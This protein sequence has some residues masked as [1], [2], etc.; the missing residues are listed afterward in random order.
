[1]V[2]SRLLLV[3]DEQDWLESYSVLLLQM[4]CVVD[5]A[6]SESE[7]RVK[8]KQ[9]KPN[10][11]LLNA[12]LNGH[13]TGDAAFLQCTKAV[14][15]AAENGVSTILYSGQDSHEPELLRKLGEFRE[16]FPDTVVKFLLRRDILTV[17][18]LSEALRG[19]GLGLPHSPAPVVTRKG[20]PARDRLKIFQVAAAAIRV[21]SELATENT[22]V[23]D[24]LVECASAVREE[25]Y[26]L[27]EESSDDNLRVR[28]GYFSISPTAHMEDFTRAIARTKIDCDQLSA[29]V[30]RFLLTLQMEHASFISDIVRSDHIEY[31]DAID[32]AF[33]VGIKD[34]PP[35][36]SRQELAHRI[37]DRANKSEKTRNDV[38]VFILRKN[39]IAL[40]DL[41]YKGS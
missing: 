8:L 41:G 29:L 33:R 26:R 6:S 31:N 10:L 5:R 40:F 18:A 9:G 2:P 25:T 34:L 14:V 28:W 36:V 20:L 7:A 17:E 1:M 21:L 12:Y 4:G 27:V 32:L 15:M 3:D 38:I 24:G 30:E 35:S 22:V 37:Q 23:P 39:P 19:V 16:L 11:M 13:C